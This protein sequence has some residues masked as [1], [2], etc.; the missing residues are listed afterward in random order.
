VGPAGDVRGTGEAYARL[1][2]RAFRR[3]DQEA[4]LE[5]YRAARILLEAVTV[6][7]ETRKASAARPAASA[8]V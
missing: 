3:G 1:A 8:Q 5:C 7:A 6:P 2:D 4:A